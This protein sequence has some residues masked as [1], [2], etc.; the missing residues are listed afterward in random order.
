MCYLV[1]IL[2]RLAF[3]RFTQPQQ[4]GAQL[5]ILLAEPLLVVL[6]EARQLALLVRTRSLD[7]QHLQNLLYHPLCL[8]Q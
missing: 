3:L 2:L 1:Y 4:L 8:L 6:D 5:D 7:V